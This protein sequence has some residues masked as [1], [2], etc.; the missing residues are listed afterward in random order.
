MNLEKFSEINRD[1]V[2]AEEMMSP[3]EKEM[4]R[5]RERG[6]LWDEIEGRARSEVEMRR[7]E[8]E[9]KL[10]SVVR[11]DILDEHMIRGVLHEYK[12]LRELNLANRIFS[13]LSYHHQAHR[14]IAAL[15]AFGLKNYGFL[16]SVDEKEIEDIRNAVDVDR[17]SQILAANLSFIDSVSSADNE[18]VEDSLKQLRIHDPEMADDYKRRF[19]VIKAMLD[20]WMNGEIYLE[21]NR[22]NFTPRKFDD[23]THEEKMKFVKKIAEKECFNFTTEQNKESEHY[24]MNCGRIPE[25]FD[26]N[27]DGKENNE[28]EK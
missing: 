6:A 12:K 26:V 9:E 28:D 19:P 2:K 14:G 16:Q 8:I 18:R 7:S 24:C 3:E 17:Y 22:D 23:A 13:D 11:K 20:K 25:G 15:G 1:T 4:S 10:R 21:G 5:S 27:W